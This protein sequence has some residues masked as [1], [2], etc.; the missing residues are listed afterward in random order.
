MY[1]TEGV[2][3][4]STAP[5]PA[6]QSQIASISLISPVRLLNFHPPRRSRGLVLLRQLTQTVIERGRAAAQVLAKFNPAKSRPASKAG[7]RRS[8]GIHIFHLIHD[9]RAGGIRITGQ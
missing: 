2:L 7:V 6:G 8:A 1:C 9:L 3:P 4:V 5:G